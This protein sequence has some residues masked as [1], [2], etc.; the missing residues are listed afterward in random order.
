MIEEILKLSGFIKNETYKASRFL[1]QPNETY[2]VYDD[3]FELT[4]S[5][6]KPLLKRHTITLRVYE[7][8]ADKNK[9]KDLENILFQYYSKFVDGY[10]KYGREWNEKT[11]TFQ[12]EYE[13]EY[14]EKL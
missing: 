1:Q 9:I 5:D 2:C 7:K 6:I 4:G 10:Q 8:Y 3:D 13:F 12:T 14:I 11:Q